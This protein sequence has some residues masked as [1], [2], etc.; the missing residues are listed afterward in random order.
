MSF[1]TAIL[2]G[3]VLPLAYYAVAIASG[4]RFF[5]SRGEAS[6]EA[7]PR[8]LPPVSILKPVRGLDRDSYGNFLRFGDLDYPEY[9]VIFAVADEDDPAISIIRR[10]IEACP[11]RP[12]RLL[13]GAPVLGESSKVNKLC[14]LVRE[15]H[16][17]LLVISDSDIRVDRSYLRSLVEHFSDPRVGL[18][19]SMYTGRREGT[20]GSVLESLAIETEF[21]PSVLVAWR[22]EGVRFA[23]GASL[24]IRRA[25]LDAVGGFEALVDYC[26]EDFELG[27]RVAGQGWRVELAASPVESECVATVGD[28]IRHS[29]RWAITRRHSR[30]GGHWGLVLTQGLPWTAAAVLAAPSG[31]LAGTYAGA[32]LVLRLTLAWTVAVRGL[33]DRALAKDLWLVPLADALGFG[34]WV[35]SLFGNEIDWRGRRFTL[36]RGRLIPVAGA[37][38]PAVR[39]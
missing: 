8:S 29:L 17:D 28:F 10:V 3:A 32:Y 27:R 16:H 20:L 7:D 25:A 2:A 30:P 18:V 35:T 15:A 26:A 4:R 21:M 14:R 9:E 22:V 24:A 6:G 38:R 13:V 36:D 11:A 19:T 5:A 34:V 23:L 1:R 39:S 33:G 31:G 12:M 37:A